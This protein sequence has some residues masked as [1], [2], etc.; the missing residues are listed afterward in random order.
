MK[1]ADLNVKLLF[2]SYPFKRFHLYLS[3]LDKHRLAEIYADNFYRDDIQELISINNHPLG[4]ASLKRFS[5]LSTHFN[6]NAYFLKN[7]IHNEQVQNGYEKLL[8][9]IFRN[10][11]SN[12]LD[13]MITRQP[14]DNVEAINALLKYRFYYVA[15][16]TVYDLNLQHINNI[17]NMDFELVEMINPK[18]YDTHT[19]QQESDQIKKIAHDNH[20]DN[21]YLCDPFFAP[22]HVKRF[23]ANIIT[24]SLSKKNHEVFAYRLDGKIRGFITTII[25]EDFNHK[26]PYRYASLDYIAVDYPYQKKNIGYVL[27][28]YALDHFRKRDIDFVSVKTMGSNYRAMRLL[29]KSRFVIGSQNMILHWKK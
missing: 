17:D 21:R 16:E 10:Q 13:F 14:V 25:N 12:Q 24:D 8:Q 28:N 3:K 11:K 27:N 1:V 18:N 7:F 29:S 4:L 23:Y 26:M 19:N 5:S 20:H 15:T 22:E 6:L 9:N 2:A